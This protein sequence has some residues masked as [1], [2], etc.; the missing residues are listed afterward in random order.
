[1][2][3][4]LTTVV[5]LGIF[6]GGPAGAADLTDG[7]AANA[8]EARRQSRDERALFKVGAAQKAKIAVSVGLAYDEDE[9]DTKAASTPFR[10]SYQTP[11]KEGWWRFQVSGD[12]YAHVRAVGAPTADG[13]ADL[14]LSVAHPLG[15]WATASFGVRLPTR[16]EVGSTSGAQSFKL[17]KSGDIADQ[18]GYFALASLGRANK[19]APGVS[20]MSQTVYG[21]VSYTTADQTLAVLAGLS[22]WHRKGAGNATELNVGCEFPVGDFRGSLSAVRGITKGARH[23][24]IGFDLTRVF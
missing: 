15:S 3:Q 21:E 6:S 24:G 13:L 19:T 7:L 23:T 17:A 16:G 10:V 11:E 9:A 18:W 1:M 22:R 2:K 8:R 14:N 4:W 20:R 12:G 5:V